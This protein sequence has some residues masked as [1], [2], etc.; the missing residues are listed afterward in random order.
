M[1]I[2][3]SRPTVRQTERSIQKMFALWCFPAQFSQASSAE[4]SCAEQ[5]TMLLCPPSELLHSSTTHNS[6]LWNQRS[7]G[8]SSPVPKYCPLLSIHTVTSSGH[9]A[10]GHKQPV[11]PER[12]QRYTGCHTHESTHT[13][14][15][16]LSAHMKMNTH[17]LIRK[18]PSQPLAVL[19]KVTKVTQ[20]LC[21][22]D[23]DD[24]E[25][26]GLVN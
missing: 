26:D 25:C 6:L 20:L 23:A 1:Q 16:N 19:T 14:T 8:H 5:H 18:D 21:L 7:P 4:Q 15:L 10:R 2:E 12:A 13:H 17:H 3:E 9:T 22:T 11:R 24:R